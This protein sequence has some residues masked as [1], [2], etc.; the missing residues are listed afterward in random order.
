MYIYKQYVYIVI[1]PASHF[2]YE[3]N[4]ATKLAEGHYEPN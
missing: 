1:G 4:R 3:K 2:T